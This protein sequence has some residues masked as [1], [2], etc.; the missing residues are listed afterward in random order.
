MILFITIFFFFCAV[1]TA[2]V[3]V[4]RAGSKEAVLVIAR[5]RLDCPEGKE[6]NESD[7]IISKSGIQFFNTTI[8]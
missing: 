4:D 2:N 7:L 5:G 6:L 1:T 3:K 8:P